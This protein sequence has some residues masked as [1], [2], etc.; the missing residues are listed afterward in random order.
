MSIF[1]YL[2]AYVLF[3]LSQETKINSDQG[4]EDVCFVGYTFTQKGWK[5]F[6]LETEEFLI[7]RDVIFKETEFLFSSQSPVPMS[8][9]VNSQTKTGKLDM[10]CL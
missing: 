7:S 9:Q 6:D 1:E 8:N 5:V 2:D 4:A 3:I 10:Y